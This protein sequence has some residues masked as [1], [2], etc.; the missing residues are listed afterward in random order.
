MTLNGRTLIKCAINW[1][2]ERFDNLILLFN[3]QSLSMSTSSTTIIVLGKD[4]S[5]N[6]L[7]LPERVDSDKKFL[8]EV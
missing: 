4:S 7:T 8:E 1:K 3:N 5:N 2:R 6:V